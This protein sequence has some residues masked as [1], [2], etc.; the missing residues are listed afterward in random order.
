[1]TVQFF[2]DIRFIIMASTTG[3]HKDVLLIISAPGRDEAWEKRIVERTGG[4]VEVRWE[5]LRKPDGS[6]KKMGELDRAKFEGLTML[7]TY[8]PV[9]AGE[10]KARPDDDEDIIPGRT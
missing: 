2:L 5:G 4:R 10:L 6:F 9:P 8:E 1:M 7:Y 3:E